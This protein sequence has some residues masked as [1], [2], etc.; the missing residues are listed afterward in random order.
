MKNKPQRCLHAKLAYALVM[1]LLPFASMAQLQS[2]I[3]RSYTFVT[4]GGLTYATF[5]TLF[6]VPAMYELLSPKEIH[7]LSEKELE[8]VDL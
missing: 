4:I 3:D 8:V 1:L 2:V 6:I 7:V 5:M